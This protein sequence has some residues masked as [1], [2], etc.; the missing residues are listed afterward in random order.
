MNPIF[1][2]LLPMLVGPI[3]G[4]ITTYAMDLIDDVLKWTANWP[5][6]VKQLI[7]M[8]LSAVIPIIG[9]QTGLTLPADPSQLA[10]QPVVQMIVGAAVA[11]F[12]KHSNDPKNVQTPAP[13]ATK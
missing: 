3:S 2:L 5:N 6:P 7:V 4:F 12:V 11:F 9:Q 8:V 1:K 13:V 10:T